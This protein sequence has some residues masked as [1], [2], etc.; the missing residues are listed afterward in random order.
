MRI[1]I[2]T[3]SPPS[4]K[5]G[6]RVTALRW[7]RIL[8]EIG[9]DVKITT[10]FVR[11][12]ADVLIALHIWKSIQSIENYRK[13][14][15]DSPLIIALTGTDLYGDLQT[16]NKILQ[17]LEWADK[18]VVLQPFG[19]DEIPPC[20]HSK[21]YVIYQSNRLKSHVGLKQTQKFKICVMG[22]LRDVKDPFRTAHAVRLLPPNSKIEVIHLGNALDKKMEMLAMEENQSNDRYTWLGGVTQSKAPRILSGCKLLVHTS[23]IEGG[24]NAVSEAI[25]IGVPVIST[26][27]SGSIGLLGT[28]YPGYFETGDTRRLAEI[29]EQ[30]EQNETF[31]QS[32]YNH[33]STLKPLFIPA[34]EKESWENLLLGAVPPKKVRNPNKH[35]SRFKVVKLKEKELLPK[36]ELSLIKGL[37]RKDKKISCEYFYDEK[38]SKL[39]EKICKLPEYYLTRTETEILESKA[40]KISQLFSHSPDV[41]ELGSG[42]SEKAG[43][44]LRELL[45]RFGY[46]HYFSID[47]S[48]EVQLQ[49]CH[50]LLDTFPNLDIWAISGE[51]LEGLDH[52]KMRNKKPRLI[53]WL[54]SS[55]GNFDRNQAVH[56]LKQIKNRMNID[57]KLLVGIDLRKEPKLLDDA[58]N[59]SRGITAEF[60]LNILK[61]INRE[62]EGT[63]EIENFSHKAVYHKKKGRIEMY[64]LSNCDQTVQLEQSGKTISFKKNERIHTENSYKYSYK[65]IEELVDNSGLNFCHHF[66]DPKNWFS[67]NIF[68]R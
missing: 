7:A 54:G 40:K 18:L 25:S 60:N 2:V 27:I 42:N 57:D 6:N 12:K 32:L 63:F 14:Y 46:V 56:F 51:Y 16:H 1:C 59:D 19:L 15:P 21:T 47:I 68:S 65:E 31:Y 4:S 5:T 43:I 62:L 39:F 28:G 66:T 48:P 53:L 34:R 45:N 55:I 24:A 38:G 10:N 35:S 22:H 20:F 50:N 52:L 26:K 17:E 67:V 49:G 36:K 30:V 58:Y 13:K 11:Q 64:L 44:I 41:V 37:E 61:R 3:P 9:H 29:L 23:K 33:V 8:R